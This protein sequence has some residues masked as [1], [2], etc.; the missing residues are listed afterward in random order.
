[1]KIEN[2]LSNPLRTS[3]VFVISIL[4]PEYYLIIEHHEWLNDF[5]IHTIIQIMILIPQAFFC[6]L[7]KNLC[8]L[9]HELSQPRDERHNMQSRYCGTVSPFN[10]TT[11][12]L[13][14]FTTFFSIYYQIAEAEF[15][16]NTR[17]LY[18]LVPKV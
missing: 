8:F 7:S 6:R 4:S 9:V 15:S 13:V 12:N 10:L 11:S 14:E 17:L 1:M 18:H 2:L 16:F 3:L 5:T